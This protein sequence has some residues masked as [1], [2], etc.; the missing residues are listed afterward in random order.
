MADNIFSDQ[1]EFLCFRN[2]FAGI[3]EGKVKGPSYYHKR[4]ENKY[5]HQGI[6]DVFQ[7]FMVSHL[8]NGCCGAANYGGK[9]HP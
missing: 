9:G 2:G 6:I 8:L 7:R 1:C 4:A 3:E 5:S